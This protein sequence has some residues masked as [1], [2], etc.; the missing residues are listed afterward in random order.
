MR[1]MTEAEFNEWKLHPGTQAV[2]EI[3]SKK[4]E[5]LR[6]AWEG[7]SFTDYE[8]GTM[9]LVNVGNIGTCRAYAFVQNLDYEQYLGEIDEREHLRAGAARSGGTD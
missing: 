3:L 2:M 5:D 4:R 8:Q 9:A 1:A 6:Q 7:G